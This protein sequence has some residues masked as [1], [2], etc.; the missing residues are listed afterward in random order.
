VRGG[1]PSRSHTL[2][3][4]WNARGKPHTKIETVNPFPCSVDYPHISVK[5]PGAVK[6][7]A[8]SQ[9]NKPVPELDLSV[10]LFVDGTPVRQTVTKASNKQYLLN[11]AT[12]LRCTNFA[13][14]HIFQGAAMGT[15]FENQQPLVQF[16]F[17]A[18]VSLRCGI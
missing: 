5:V 11:E 18:K 12:F 6:V 16:K 4:V 17:G 7:N 3:T 8:K 10:T 2:H 1:Q 13:E 15:S 14:S 9:C